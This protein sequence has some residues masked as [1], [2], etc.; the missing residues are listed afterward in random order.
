LPHLI[1]LAEEYADEGVVVA[2][3]L[4]GNRTS[5]VEAFIEEVG[6]GDC[7]LTDESEAAYSS[8]GIRGVPTTILIDEA[9]RLMFRH[10]GFEEGMEEQFEAEIEAL[11]AWRSEA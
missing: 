4:S 6:A 9:G 7:V 2:A 5:T 1:R 8:Y 3:V 11:L 10:V